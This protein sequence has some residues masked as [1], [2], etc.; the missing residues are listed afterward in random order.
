M[1]V[2]TSGLLG[3]K[4]DDKACAL[5][6]RSL[7]RNCNI[8][9][10]RDNHKTANLISRHTVDVHLDASARALRKVASN[11]VDC[12]ARNSIGINRLEA[13][14]VDIK[15]SACL[16]CS[17]KWQSQCQYKSEKM[18][19]S[20]KKLLLRDKITN[21]SRKIKVSHPQKRRPS[22]IVFIYSTASKSRTQQLQRLQFSTSYWL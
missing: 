14:S 9:T 13:T 8:A 21:F 15:K 1:E 18:S 10:D 11:L 20:E 4:L 16:R 5:D 3:C 6:R 12:H 19:H 17:H 7:S 22:R 2:E